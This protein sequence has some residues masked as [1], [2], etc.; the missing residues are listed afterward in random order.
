MNLNI[1][2]APKD[3]HFVPTEDAV[4]EASEYLEQEIQDYVEFIEAGVAQRLIYID[5]GDSFMSAIGCPVCK[6][7]VSADGPHE[8]WVQDLREDLMSN[9][10]LDLGSHRISM[11]CCNKEAPVVALDFGGQAGFARFSITLE[12]ADIEDQEETLLREL[13]KILG[14]ELVKIELAST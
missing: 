8:G 14:C 5:E 9:Q 10:K 2:L 4:S 11:P 1:V 3:I 13:G 6:S 12:G 7:N